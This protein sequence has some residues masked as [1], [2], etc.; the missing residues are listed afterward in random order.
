MICATFVAQTHYSPPYKNISPG[1]NPR[2]PNKLPDP[3][4]N[5]I[6][7]FSACSA[8][9]LGGVAVSRPNYAL[10]LTVALWNQTGFDK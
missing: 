3:L 9:F 4:Y 6:N 2:C 7:P 10:L 1:P 5:N 8:M